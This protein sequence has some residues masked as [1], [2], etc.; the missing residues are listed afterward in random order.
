MQRSARTCNSCGAPE[1]LA[2]SR[3]PP[4]SPGGG[5][6]SRFL[7]SYCA[8]LRILIVALIVVS[9]RGVRWETE[10][11]HLRARDPASLHPEYPEREAG[12]GTR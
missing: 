9:A 10:A 7:S 3:A 12:S 8:R 5:L 2:A 11:A 6:L 1:V 4:R